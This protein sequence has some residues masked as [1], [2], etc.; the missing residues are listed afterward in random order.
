MRKRTFYEITNE[1]VTVDT[2]GLMKMT[3]SGRTTATAIGR[4]AEAQIRIGR[5]VLWNVAKVQRYLDAV[6]E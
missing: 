3:N 6:S 1:T 5:K 4:A 2:S